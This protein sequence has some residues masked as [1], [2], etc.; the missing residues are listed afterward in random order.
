MHD[1]G[2]RHPAAALVQP[3]LEP[4]E[5]APE[6]WSW[7][8]WLELLQF[9]AVGRFAGRRAPNGPGGDDPD[10]EPV[11]TVLLRTL[12]GPILV[13]LRAPVSLLRI[14]CHI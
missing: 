3:P 7:A 6:V 13:Q 12:G 4:W 11:N 14:T 5:S 2:P 10:P 9:L 8:K 1:P